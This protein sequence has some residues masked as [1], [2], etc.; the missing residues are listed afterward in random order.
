MFVCFWCVR[1]CSLCKTFTILLLL[2]TQMQTENSYLL[3]YFSFFFFDSPFPEFNAHNPILIA[4]KLLLETCVVFFCCFCLFCYEILPVYKCSRF[5]I[6]H[7]IAASISIWIVIFSV[8]YIFPPNLFVFIFCFFSFFINF[9]WFHKNSW[10]CVEHVCIYAAPTQSFT[11]HKKP[12]FG[13]IA[14]DFFMC[15]WMCVCMRSRIFIFI[16]FL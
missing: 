12:R 14:C 5:H 13:K 9:Q 15:M 2:H 4:H 10:V 6:I 11:Q 8:F 3:L 7:S 1:V 16:F